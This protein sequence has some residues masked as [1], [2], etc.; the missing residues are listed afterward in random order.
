MREK[1]KVELKRIV[2][3]EYFFLI[4]VRSFMNKQKKILALDLFLC[5]FWPFFPHI[6]NW[7]QQFSIRHF[8]QFMP[9]IFCLLCKENYYQSAVMFY[10]YAK[11][12]MKQHKQAKPNYFLQAYLGTMTQLCTE[13]KN[14]L[15]IPLG[16]TNIQ[17]MFWRFSW[18]LEL[19][20]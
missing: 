15:E 20:F 17:M 9:V 19:N 7:H 14:S 4:K 2:K 1:Y 11:N 8:G 3:G 10:W 16:L 6:S 13:K 18:W 5:L 12:I